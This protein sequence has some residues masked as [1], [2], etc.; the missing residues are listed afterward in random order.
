MSILIRMELAEPRSSILMGNH[1]LY[2]V[3]VTEHAILEIFFM[4]TPMLIGGFG[5]LFVPLIFGLSDKAFPEMN[6]I[7]FWLLTPSLFL[8]L[9]SALGKKFISKNKQ[10]LKAPKINL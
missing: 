8:L 2:N 4:I 9:S 6:N 7:S 3:L 5:N 1:Q 10:V